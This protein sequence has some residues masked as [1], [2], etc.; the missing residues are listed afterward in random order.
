MKHDIKV[1]K[2]GLQIKISEIQSEHEEL[3]IN[4]Q[5]CQEGK[6]DCPSDEYKKLADLTI[7]KSTDELVL[8]L[9]AKSKQQFDKSEVEKCVEYVINK[10]SKK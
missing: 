8:D 7:K 4:F 6:C 5:S 2:D 10:V 1:K 9:K 3:M